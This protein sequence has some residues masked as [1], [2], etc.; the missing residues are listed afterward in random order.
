MDFR[1]QSSLPLGLRNNNPGDFRT[2]VSWL[3]AVGSE[4]GF[5]TFSDIS[6]GLRALGY[7]LIQKYNQ[8]GLTTVIAIITKYAPPSENNTDAYIASVAQFMG[9][10]PN[11]D[12]NLNNDSTVLP[13]L[14]RAI[15]NQELGATYS[16]MVTDADIETGIGMIPSNILG[17]IQNFFAADPVAASAVSFGTVAVVIVVVVMVVTKTNFKTAFKTVL[18]AIRNA[19]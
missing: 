9:I 10:D 14:M 1:G 2:G 8:D 5:I 18:N 16:A 4:N 3:G 12:L 17:T 6:W 15:M 13:S 7:D 19:V 11:Q